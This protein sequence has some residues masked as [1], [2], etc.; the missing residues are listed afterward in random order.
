MKTKDLTRHY[1][2]GLSA[3]DTFM[4]WVREIETWPIRC[5][6]ILG[7]PDPA[8]PHPSPNDSGPLNGPLCAIGGD[9]TGSLK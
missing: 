7:P 2:V 6:P 4:E 9:S 1:G 5:E 3:S 8:L